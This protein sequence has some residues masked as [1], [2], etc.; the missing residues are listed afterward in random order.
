MKDAP[1][2]AKQLRV[3]QHVLRQEHYNHAIIM[4]DFNFAN[5]AE[6]L[7]VLGSTMKDYT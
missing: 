3:I 7:G 1:I 6:R 5:S 4:G 2:R